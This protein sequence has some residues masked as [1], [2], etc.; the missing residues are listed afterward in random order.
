MST[1][2]S[3]AKELPQW[4]VRFSAHD[5]TVS[6]GGRRIVEDVSLTLQ[7]GEAIVLRGPN[8]AGKTTL[9]RA[10]AGLLS[11][12]AGMVSCETTSTKKLLE[13]AQS[14]CVFLG[15]AN[16]HKPSL[17][18]NENLKFWAKLYGADENKV[19][20]ALSAFDL[21]AYADRLAGTL[22]TGLS[23][24]LGLCRLILADRPV[25]FVDEPTASLD[26]ASSKAFVARLEEHLSRGGCAIIAA[27]D[28][29]TVEGARNV[30]LSYH[31]A[32]PS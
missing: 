2:P 10:F 22:S 11:A 31:E 20:T 13:E 17:T 1:N 7:P 4:D 23:R 30:A 14:L 9:L 8:G 27:H 29:L 28:D 32:T 25:W 26:D 18:V 15:V 5:M 6:R 16:A 19:M 12:E 24:R 3:V 21:T